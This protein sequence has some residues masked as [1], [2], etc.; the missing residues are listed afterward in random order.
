MPDP[1]PLRVPAAFAP[2]TPRIPCRAPTDE[3]LRAAATALKAG[4]LIVFPTET[5]YGLGANALSD[6]AVAGIFAAKGRPANNPVIV[7]I[8]TLD[9]AKP[10]AEV[11]G[12]ARR[13]AKAFWPGPLTLVL[14][15]LADSPL[16]RRVSA[17]GETVALR[18]PAHPIAL[19]LLQAAGLPVA[20]P[21]AN[22]SGAI[23]PTRAEDVALG[24]DG[25]AGPLP[26]MILNG[27]PCAVG[28]ESTVL[29]LTT[30][31]PRLLRPGAVTREAIGAVLGHGIAD[32]GSP[33]ALNPG[34]GTRD[35]LPAP[36][37]LS[38][39]YAPDRPVRL[40]ATA[41]RSG[42]ALLGFAGT[43]G[44]HLDLSPSGDLDEAARN[45]FAMLRR[46]DAPPFRAIA[47]APV[48]ATGLGLAINDRL[49]RAAAP[50]P[51]ATKRS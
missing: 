2:G 32:G 49:S 17:G 50:R 25:S 39:H 9:D 36:G 4:K 43:P 3:T 33:I 6:E 21:S 48:P 31:P 12:A 27:G 23:S 51:P 46:L 40:N 29:D 44:A 45:L 38:S 30:A 1:S 7:H 13:L 8:A 37:L 20:A 34:A 18:A 5:V 14:P 42:E 19:S 28:L 35:P 10:L 15:R 22:R 41:A 47:V 11:T 16:A 24:L 26:A